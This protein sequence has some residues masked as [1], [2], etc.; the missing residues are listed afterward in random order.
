MFRAPVTGYKTLVCVLTRPGGIGI[1][2]PAAGNGVSDLQRCATESVQRTLGSL[3]LTALAS[4]L[5]I[6]FHIHAGMAIFLIARGNKERNHIC[7][8]GKKR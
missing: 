7:I 3:T 8:A 5:K 2:D 6:G 4:Q 1:K